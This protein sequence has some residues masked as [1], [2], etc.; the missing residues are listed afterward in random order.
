MMLT[1]TIFVLYWFDDLYVNAIR[2]HRSGIAC[3]LGDRTFYRIKVEIILNINLNNLEMTNS[4][5]CS[6]ISY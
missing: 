4:D 1:P 5:N 6:Y 2:F 3:A